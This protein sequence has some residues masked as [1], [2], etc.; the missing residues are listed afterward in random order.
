[1]SK[2]I[3]RQDFHNREIDELNKDIELLKASTRDSEYL[4]SV[5]KS[6]NEIDYQYFNEIINNVRSL[7]EINK[8]YL[9]IDK[10]KDIIN[11]EIPYIIDL[12]VQ[13]LL[14]IIPKNQLIETQKINY[15]NLVNSFYQDKI[16]EI[17]KIE[18]TQNLEIQKLAKHWQ[19]YN[20]YKPIA[21]SQFDPKVLSGLLKR[22]KQED[23]KTIVSSVYNLMKKEINQ[24][25]DCKKNYK[26]RIKWFLIMLPFFIVLLIISL[27]LILI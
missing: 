26:I 7:F 1:M 3:S 15:D 18:D 20:T 13:E 27:V 16:E 4:S 23:T 11:F 25:E 5:I 8:Y 10:N 6:L 21:K 17:K 2:F 9:D 19:T 24:I 12:Y 14:S 22:Y